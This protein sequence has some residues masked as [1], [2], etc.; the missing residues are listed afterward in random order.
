MKTNRSI[1]QS[2]VIPVLIYPDVRQAVDWLSRAFGFTERVR[3]GEDHR[4]Q[5]SFGDGA[6]IVGDVRG[7]RRPPRPGEVT[8]SVMVRVEDANAHCERAKA[9]GAH[10]LAGP[11]DFEYGE[12]QYTAEDPAGHHWTFSESIADVAPETWGGTSVSHA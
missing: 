1:P 2:T 11:T 7:E 9:E 6:V 10:I 4:S 5:L 3:I 8:H 12:R